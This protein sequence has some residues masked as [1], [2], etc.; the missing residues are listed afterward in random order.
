MTTIR[1]TLLKLAAIGLAAGAAPAL[2]AQTAWP[3]QPVRMVIPFPPGGPTD[4]VGRVLAQALSEQLG[5][6]VIVENKPGANANIAAELVARAPADGYTFM[7][8]TS[9]LALSAVLYSKLNYD[10]LKDFAP[11]AL[12]AVVPMVLVVHPSVPAKTVPEFIDLLKKNPGKMVYGSAGNGNVTHLGAFQFLQA[13]GLSA[14]H[15]P[16][17]GSSPALVDLAG[18]QT[19]FMTDTINSALPYI[20]D[21]RMRA[22][23][24]TSAKRS[25]VLP[26]V[27][28]LQE[29]GMAGFEV[30]AWQGVV[31]PAKTPPEIVNKLN[32]EI[33]K[34]LKN[35]AVL[36]KLAAQ[37]AQPLGSTPEQYGA[38]LR[39][40]IQR[41]GEVAKATGAKLD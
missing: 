35:P 37:G 11:V 21:G 15:V 6:N 23:A 29:S 17:K 40:E 4:L 10:A 25:P 12:T 19:Q 28:T 16:Y 13:N 8:N 27:P 41:W 39:S 14:T 2:H 38:Y 36:E 22:L 24:V 7:Y 30:G 31:M 3:T 5:Q 20:R 26:D 9:S 33:T 34:A 32:A 18:G 1:R